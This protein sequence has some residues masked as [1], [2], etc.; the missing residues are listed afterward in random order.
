MHI[1]QQ[2]IVQW[3][4]FKSGP[5]RKHNEAAYQL[6]GDVKR[7]FRY[8][9]LEINP[10]D[11]D[12]TLQLVI[13]GKSYRLADLGSAVS[14]IILVLANVAIR[15]PAYVLID[16]PES[17]LHPSLQLEFMAIL[18]HYARNGVLFATHNIGLARAS[19]EF[20][21]TLRRNGN[22][23]EVRLL[24]STARL[25]DFLS[26]ISFGGYRDLG[27]KK[28]LL[29]DGTTEI[30]TVQHFL[31]Q[32]NKD[33]LV[34]LLPLGG[35]SMINGL[36]DAELAEMRRI[37]DDVSV[38]IDSERKTEGES[39]LQDRQEFVDLCKRMNISVCV[40]ERRA[41]ENYF[42]QA[43]IQKVKGDKYHAL[44]LYQKLSDAQFGWAKSDNWR[45]AQRL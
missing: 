6:T 45:I 42:T 39:L 43:A 25:W 29:V 17:N 27:F 18:E 20:V 7:L 23:S 34:V 37:C 40:L 36:R 22:G 14:Q 41:T 1:G 30:K 35:G 13:D 33:H 5:T 16:E 15:R 10:S 24:E 8:T 12:K 44:T 4:M 19:A 21:Y 11:D 3:R 9:S 26:E 28:I 38:L 31:R 2:F 32:R